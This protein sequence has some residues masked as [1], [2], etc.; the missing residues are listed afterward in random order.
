[1]FRKRNGNIFLTLF[2]LNILMISTTTNA[3]ERRQKQFRSDQAY[4]FSPLP[5]SIPGVGSGVMFTSL[6]ANLFGSYTDIFA[7]VITGDATGYAFGFADLHIVPEVMYLNYHSRVID[8]ASVQSYDSRGMDADKDEFNYYELSQFDERTLD[9]AVTFFDRRLELYAGVRTLKTAIK[10]IRN[11]EG[12][13][14]TEFDS[15]VK[16]ETETPFIGMTV[17]YT[18]DWDDPTVGIRFKTVYESPTRENRREADFS[19]LNFSLGAYIPIG[20]NI[21]W[22]FNFQK[23]DAIVHNEGETDR[24]KTLNELGL[25]CPTYDICKGEDQNMINNKIAERRYGTAK[26]LGGEALM[27]AYPVERFRAAHMN[28]FST[29]LRWNIVTDVIPFDFWIWKDISTSIQLAFFYEAGSVSDREE[30]LN[31]KIATDKG[32]GLRMVAKSG[33]VYRADFASGDEGNNISVMVMYPW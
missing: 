6:G 13:I 14:I 22:A 1:M 25:Q 29:E 21:T 12:K 24:Q 9:M 10:R 19:V 23:S 15:P 27:R 5:Y 30:D 7:I 28:Y 17:D 33:F 18:D 4:F 8:K 32:L 11:P 31:D 16:S 26:S 20:S 3:V 2:V